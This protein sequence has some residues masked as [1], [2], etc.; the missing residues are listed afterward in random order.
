MGSGQ[1]AAV[2]VR[3]LC[4]DKGYGQKQLWMERAYFTLYFTVHYR[5]QSG[6]KLKAGAL[7]QERKQQLWK[8]AAYWLVPHVLLSLLSYTTQVA[9]PEVC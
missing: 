3:I 7:R 5:G 6:Q 1:G 2:L 4:C 9:A 8:D